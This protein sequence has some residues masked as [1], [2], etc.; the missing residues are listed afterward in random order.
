M[1]EWGWCCSCVASGAEPCLCP[2]HLTL[3]A[4]AIPCRSPALPKQ[5]LAP[6]PAP[7]L[8]ALLEWFS[9]KARHG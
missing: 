2:H 1:V 6:G 4:T 8:L 5:P 7:S 9:L 3:P